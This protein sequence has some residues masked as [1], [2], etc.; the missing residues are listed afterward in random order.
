MWL[1][2]PRAPVHYVAGDTVAPVRYAADRVAC[3]RTLCGPPHHR[4][5]GGGDDQHAE[6]LALGLRVM[7]KLIGG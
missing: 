2:T 7:L 1:M 5:H 6:L 3:P 4:Q